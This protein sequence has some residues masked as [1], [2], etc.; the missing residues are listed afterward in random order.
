MGQATLDTGKTMKGSS[1][2]FS[3]KLQHN[4]FQGICELVQMIDHK[5]MDGLILDLETWMNC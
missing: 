2:M 3:A 4:Q 5:E 1:Q